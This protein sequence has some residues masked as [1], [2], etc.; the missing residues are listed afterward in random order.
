M[1]VGPAALDTRITLPPPNTST[2]TRCVC[3]ARPLPRSEPSPP[4]QLV[5]ALRA[6]H[7]PTLPKGAHALRNCWRHP[8]RMTD[9]HTYSLSLTE[10]ICGIGGHGYAPEMQARPRHPRAGRRTRAVSGAACLQ[11]RC[12]LV[13]SMIAVWGPPLGSAARLHLRHL[14]V[15]AVPVVLSSGSRPAATLQAV[16]R[17]PGTWQAAGAQRKARHGIERVI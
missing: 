17:V 10:V 8:F 5:S 14:A 6:H 15:A 4:W 12:W 13:Q 11:L 7:R 2:R 9:T 1:Q 3:L 16:T